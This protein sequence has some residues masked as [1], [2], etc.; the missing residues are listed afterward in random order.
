MRENDE[1]AKEA[2]LLAEIWQDVL[3]V[4]HVAPDDDFFSLGGD[5]LLAIKIVSA[6]QERGL[7]L[8]LLHLFRNPTPRGAA[9][10][11]PVTRP[12]A[13]AA[14]LAP[15]DLA[16]VP[17][18]AETAYPATRL[19]LG[20]VYTSLAT[21]GELYVD[22]VSR[23]VNLRLDASALRTALDTMSARHPALRTR[24]DLASFSEPVQ[25]VLRSAPLPLTVAEHGTDDHEAVMSELAA[26]F[27]PETAPLMRVH[28]A[29]AGEAAFR[30]SY[31]FH[32][33]VLDGW[34]ESVFLRELVTIYAALLRG[35]RLDLATPAPFAEY[36]RLE[37]S[38][39]SDVESR[40]HFASF[41]G[42]QPATTRPL[43]GRAALRKIIGTVPSADAGGLARRGADWGVPMKSLL[44]AACM[45]TVGS[46]WQEADPTVGLAVSGRPELPGADLTL[47][48]F[49]NHLPVRFETAGASWRTAAE[50]ALRAE[51]E[52]LPHRRFPYSEIRALAGGETFEV[53]LNYMRFHSRDE[54]LDAGLVAPEEDMRDHT[55]LP[56]R[57]EAFDDPRGLGLSLLVTVDVARYGEDL[58][59]RLLDGLL[60]ALHEIATDPAEEAS[61]R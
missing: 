9:S 51:N 26:P 5:S 28:A 31:S 35:G 13:P 14:L 36:V 38:A 60:A 30:L 6:A 27:D 22:V 10:A 18:E 48:L 44:L 32:H 8:T 24:F 25:V 29:A 59:P 56:V 23:V 17:E 45:V 58:P 54:L 49:L 2:V 19:Q 3:R 11:G 41:R 1:P 50:R 12:A 15:E 42:H 4:D 37:R 53:S 33:A 57:V 61:A 47:G 52:L 46:V 40:R 39:L 20:L 7:P 43:P 16:L 34:S 55:D 21:A